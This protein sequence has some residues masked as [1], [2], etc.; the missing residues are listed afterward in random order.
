MHSDILGIVEYLR[1]CI[2]G[3]HSSEDAALGLGPRDLVPLDKHVLGKDLHGIQLAR[4]LLANEHHL[5]EPTPLAVDIH[6][7]CM[8]RHE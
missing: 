2:F 5:S 1:A 8:Q 7:I 4:V 6:A 3:A